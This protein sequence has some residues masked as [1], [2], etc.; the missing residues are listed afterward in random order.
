MSEQV[1]DA[2][3]LTDRI[4]RA[5]THVTA[6]EKLKLESGG[7]TILKGAVAGGKQ[8]I[9]KVGGDLNIES[10][11]DTSTYDSKQQNAGFS[12]SVGAGKVNGSLSYG[13]SKVNSDYANRKSKKSGFLSSS[14]KVRRDTVN[15]TTSLASTFSCN[16]TT[17]KAGQDIEIKGSNVVATGDL[18]INAWRDLNIES[19]T[20]TYNETHYK[21]EKI[22]SITA[23]GYKAGRNAGRFRS[24]IHRERLQA[25]P[26]QDF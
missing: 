18:A 7:D 24:A 1:A 22:R 12:L 15:S 16:T 19:V 25:L 9:A 14:S 6:G 20:E 13:Q 2:A 23:T 11:Q 26:F 5:N 21:S 17:M 4:A 3:N 8:V 10:L